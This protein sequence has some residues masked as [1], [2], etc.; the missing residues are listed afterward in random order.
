MSMVLTTGLSMDLPTTTG[1]PNKIKFPSFG[2]LTDSIV[3]RLLTEDRLT[4]LLST[5]MIVRARNTLLVHSLISN[6]WQH[7]NW[8]GSVLLHSLAVHQAPSH[9]VLSKKLAG[10][11]LVQNSKIPKA[12]ISRVENQP[13]RRKEPLFTG[14][15]VLMLETQ[16]QW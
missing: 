11:W 10:A 1:L 8:M 13:Y 7:S 5:M 9:G 4:T 15:S 16:L 3:L 12:K 2:P 6:P 14:L